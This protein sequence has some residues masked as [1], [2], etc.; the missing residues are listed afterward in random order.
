MRR[1]N[2][3]PLLKFFTLTRA[4]AERACLPGAPRG[5]WSRPSLDHPQSALRGAL[6]V[7]AFHPS[8]RS[9]ARRTCHAPDRRDRTSAAHPV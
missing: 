7:S 2:R 3:M 1:M 6:F 4:G 8:T 9:T 5:R